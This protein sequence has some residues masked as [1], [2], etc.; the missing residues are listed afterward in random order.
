MTLIN[1]YNFVPLKG[2]E[3]K[4]SQWADVRKHDRLAKETFSGQL[5]LVLQAVT[6]LLIP[7]HFEEDVDKAPVDTNQGVREKRTYKRFHHRGERPTIPASSIK[8][9][10]RSVFEALTNSCL[11]LYGETYSGLT[12]PAGRFRHEEC[13]LE[14]GLCPTCSLFGTIHGEK[15]L[16][17]G[18]VRFSDAIGE[19]SALELGD[20]ILKELSS[21]KPNRHV[22]FY[23]KDGTSEGSGP[24]G[25]KFYYHHDPKL[26]SE[27]SYATV[28]N[29]MHRNARILERLKQNSQLTAKVSFQNL[30]RSELA[31]LLYAIE[32]EYQV[33]EDHG[34]Q[35][36]KFSLGHKIGM[37]KPLGF[38]SV[39]VAISRGFITEGA[40][41]YLS[42][43]RVRDLDLRA[44]IE[45]F[46]EEVEQPSERFHEIFA[47]SKYEQGTIKYPGYDWF[48]DLDNKRKVLGTLGEFEGT[49]GLL[50]EQP[51]RSALITPLPPGIVVNGVVSEVFADKMIVEAENGLFYERRKNVQGVKAHEIVRGLQITLKG[52][53]VYPLGKAPK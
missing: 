22:P 38:G 39:V 34:K 50:S 46:R 20:W 48:Q 42:L 49:A 19:A 41:S 24:R 37:G 6:P 21:P 3:P 10:I 52:N 32:L 30:S 45:R 4:R 44:R 12:Y 33:V 9:M 36:L 23:S 43:V 16:F 51:S 31:Y 7:S 15:L 35:R 5:Q 53:A 1:P 28:L 17:Q 40:S 29:H 14:N 26:A 13:N 8:G 47:L 2:Q 27:Q 25:R 18:K 11:T